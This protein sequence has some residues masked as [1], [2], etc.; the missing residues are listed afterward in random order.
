MRKFS[1]GMC[2][3]LVLL[4]TT[5]ALG[6]EVGDTP[7]MTWGEVSYAATESGREEGIKFDGYF[8][9]GYVA[10]NVGNGWSL[11]PYV[12]IRAT[13]SENS[14]ER[15]NNRV[16]PFAGLEVRKPIDLG[17]GKWAEVA[18]GIRGGYY[19]YFDGNDGESQAHIYVSFGAGGPRW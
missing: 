11:I 7:W 15:W 13:A 3:A 19:A 16:G 12:S 10:S 17:N 8:E 9:Q 18:V 14:E 2:S 5:P 1:L 6:L 4:C